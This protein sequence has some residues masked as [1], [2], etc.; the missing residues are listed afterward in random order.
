MNNTTSNTPPTTGG[1]PRRPRRPYGS[2]QTDQT[3]QPTQPT[4]PTQPRSADA[5]SSANDTSSGN[6]GTHTRGESRAEA[7]GNGA[8]KWEAFGQTVYVRDATKHPPGASYTA[9]V[10]VGIFCLGAIIGQASTTFVAFSNMIFDDP[11]W[12]RLSLAAQNAGRLPV[13]GIC[14][15]I[16]AS[17]QAPLLFMGFKIDKR[18]ASE[19][20]KRLTL[21]SK[22][23]MILSVTGEI[24]AG[25]VLLTIWAVLALVADTLGDVGF[26]NNYTSNPV[27]LFFYATGLYG[28]STVGMSE[29]LQ[30]LWDGMVTAEWLKHVRAANAWA[31][32][33]V[34]EFEEARRRGTANANQAQPRAKT[35]GG[36]A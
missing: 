30:L 27:V 35:A 4:R 21:A 3:T 16:A 24:V 29:C 34:Q 19:R 9:A 25:N 11:T 2:T 5:T 10:I 18:W 33:K 8:V 13:D 20:H 6:T 31:M 22:A 14:L 28:L 7:I 1:P 32:M 15:M 36:T 12:L 23:T 17:F 26:L